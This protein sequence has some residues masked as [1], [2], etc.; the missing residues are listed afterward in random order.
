MPMSTAMATNDQ[1][2]PSLVHRAKTLLLG[3]PLPDRVPDRVVKAIAKEQDQSE[4]LVSVIQLLAIGSFAVLYTLTPKGF[5]VDVAFEP[6]PFTLAI[7]MVFTIVRLSLALRQRLPRWFIAMSVVVDVVVLLVTIWSFH[8]Q[9]EAP[10]ALYLKAPTLMYV[11]I[12]IALRT[13]RFEPVMVILTGVTASIGWGVLL[14]YAVAHQQACTSMEIIKAITGDDACNITHMFSTYMTSYEILVG[15]ELDKMVSIFMVTMIL[16]IALVRARKLLIRAATEH[17]AAAD[18]SRF[19]APEVAGRIRDTD[20]EIAPGDAELRQAAIIMT[21]LRGFTP[22]TEQLPP[23][24]VMALLSDYQSRVVAAISAEGGSIDKFMGDGILASFGAASPSERPAAQAL[25]AA[26][27]ILAATRLWQRER[28]VANLPAPA[29]GLAL[30]TG[31]VMFGAI[32]DANRLEY[33]VIGDPV[34]LVAK[35]E[36]HTKEEK[37]RALCPLLAYQEALDQGYQPNGEPEQRRARKVEGV[38]ADLDLVVLG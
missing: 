22:L 12:L 4:V 38:Q 7:Y 25:R 28:E 3:A 8:L 26:D 27:A 9:Y 32:G 33:T 37:V 1:K 19:F 21:D 13:L 11:F 29:V 23:R 16:A 24:K 36:K 6:V 18:L 35:L 10:P 5:G 14:I 2:A 34:N 17:Q 15:A 30:T 31:T 20:V